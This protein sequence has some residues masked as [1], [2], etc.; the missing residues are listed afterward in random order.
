MVS[1]DTDKLFTVRTA[2]VPAAPTV[3]SRRQKVHNLEAVVGEGI[4]EYSKPQRL[5]LDE[6]KKKKFDGKI[7]LAR[8]P[9]YESI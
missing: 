3:L 4:D 9:T 1:W 5:G 2:K 7:G 6:K 8:T